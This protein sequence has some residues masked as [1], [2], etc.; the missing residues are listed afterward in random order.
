[1]V[2]HS[3][4]CTL[5]LNISRK[6]AY[7]TTQQW[8]LTFE[9]WLYVIICGLTKCERQCYCM[10]SEDSIM[11]DWAVPLCKN[12][13]YISALYAVVLRGS[14]DRH[15]IDA[16]PCEHGAHDGMRTLCKYAWSMVMLCGMVW[17]S[18]QPFVC[19]CCL[20]WEY[21]IS[22]HTVHIRWFHVLALCALHHEAIYAAGSP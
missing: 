4:T 5:H 10:K 14:Y 9:H 20:M 1:M 22:G 6:Q 19:V 3:P 11:F 16:F 7:C 18:A 8:P 21:H 17:A 13:E 15:H 2:L 12:M